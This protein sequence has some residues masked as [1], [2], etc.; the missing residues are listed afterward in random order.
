MLV[1][2]I[3]F[4]TET[5]YCHETCPANLAANRVLELHTLQ[6]QMITWLDVCMKQ[7]SVIFLHFVVTA[8]ELHAYI[9]RP[10]PS[11]LCASV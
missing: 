5:L 1:H 9:F 6:Y 11:M 2:I 4:C 10:S 8:N 7:C 3:I